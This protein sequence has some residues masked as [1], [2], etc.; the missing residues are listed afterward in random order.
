[1][2]SSRYVRFLEDEEWDRTTKAEEKQQ[3]VS[4]DPDEL[5]DDV[6]ITVTKLLSEVYKRSNVVV[7]EPAEYEEA[8]R[9]TKW[10]EAMKD[11]LS[12]IE[13]NN[14]WEFVEKLADRKVIGVNGF[15]KPI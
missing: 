12:M 2:V 15:L 14:T 7:L 6:P 11:E 9:D 4:L 8:K 10:I 5:V 13:K 3:K 1:M